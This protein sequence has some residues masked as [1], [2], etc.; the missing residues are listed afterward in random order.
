MVLGR[1][2]EREEDRG[3]G[4]RPRKPK[5]LR[6]AYLARKLLGVNSEQPM[7]GAPGLAWNARSQGK[8]EVAALGVGMCHWVIWRFICPPQPSPPSAAAEALGHR[9]LPP[10]A[11]QPSGAACR[12]QDPVW[13]YHLTAS[14]GQVAVGRA[15]LLVGLAPWTEVWGVADHEVCGGVGS[16]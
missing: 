10:A 7:G 3:A 4:R 11:R 13:R 2:V 16:P 14:M 8:L 15:G 6:H 5:T 12:G 1:H 9:F